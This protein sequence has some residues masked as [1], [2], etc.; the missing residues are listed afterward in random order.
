MPTD[1]PKHAPDAPHSNADMKTTLSHMQNISNGLVQPLQLSNHD[2]WAHHNLSHSFMVHD[3]DTSNQTQP[4]QPWQIMQQQF[5]EDFWDIQQQIQ[6]QHLT[7]E[8]KI[9]YFLAFF[10]QRQDNLS[11]TVSSVPT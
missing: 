4:Q 1:L 2:N 3:N 9:K 10:K 8:D 7:L 5:D 11:Q 6:E